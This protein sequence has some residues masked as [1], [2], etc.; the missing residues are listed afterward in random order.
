MPNQRK[1]STERSLCPQS[2]LDEARRRIESGESKRSVALS[3]GMKESTLRYRLKRTEAA[4]KLGR[5]D[6][7]FSP[8]TEEEFCK[9]L[10][11]LDNM[12]Q[13]MTAKDLR[14]LAY[15]FAVRNNITH[16]FNTELKMAGKH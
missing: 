11:N 2:I 10:E 4:T 9:Y 15:E 8:E 16:R 14:T 3:Y 1:R 12:F 13:G 5:Y 6:V 7:T